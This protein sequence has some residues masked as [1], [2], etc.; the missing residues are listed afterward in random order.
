MGFQM[1][2]NNDKT[3]IM[4]SFD[5]DDL[6]MALLLKKMFKWLLPRGYNWNLNSC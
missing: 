1:Y 5:T 2:N 4:L 3:N 6:S